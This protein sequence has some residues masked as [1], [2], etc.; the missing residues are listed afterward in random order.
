MSSGTPICL[1]FP[2]FVM[3]VSQIVRS[4]GSGSSSRSAEP[5]EGRRPSFAGAVRGLRAAASAALIACGGGSG[6]DITPPTTRDTTAPTVTATTPTD[7]AVDVTQNATVSVTFSEPIN[8]VTFTA[9]SVTVVAAGG[10]SGAAVA[11]TVAMNGTTA[12]FTPT[13]ALAGSTRY[14]VTITTAVKDLA[15]NALA[16]DYV[17]SFT[18]S[19]PPDLTAPTVLSVTPQNDAVNVSVAVAPTVTLSEP[20]NVATLNASTIMLTKSGDTTRVAATVTVSANTATLRPAAALAEGVKYTMTAT[21]GIKDVAGNSLAAELSWS[22]TT[23]PRVVAGS[24]MWRVDMPGEVTLLDAANRP[25]IDVAGRLL[26]RRSASFTY[27]GIDIT[28]GALSWTTP[29]PTSP[30]ASWTFGTLFAMSGSYVDPTTGSVFWTPTGPSFGPGDNLLVIGET[31]VFKLRGDT[32]GGFDRRT[33]REKWRRRLGPLN[34]PDPD[35]C[36]ILRAIGLD[37][38]NGYVLRSSSAESQ[39]ITLSD[40]GIVRE[41]VASSDVARRVFSERQLAVVHGANLIVAWSNSLE[42]AAGVDVVTGTQRWRTDFST[43]GAAFIGTPTER[44]FYT[45]DG[46]L[47]LLE[48]PGT[49]AAE[50]VLF[51]A[52]DTRAG[53]F[54]S[55]R[56]LTRTENQVALLGR[57]E[58]AALLC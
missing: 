39:I 40:T 50:A 38:A 20:M 53:T 15:G 49:T 25:A 29:M 57:C 8:A 43:I 18:T 6:T 58:S 13:K 45:P 34:C 47:L 51:T 2:V 27:S 26:L 7:G 16:A 28:T 44:T 12:T 22:F 46:S 11:G 19:T 32:L 30:Y 52:L 5:T 21:T 33:G 14:T 10:A 54:T 35:V 23:V 31:I 3:P 56:V 36:G 9:T 42:A 48:F 55:R 1:A 17:W 37:S 41:V 4:L 24:T